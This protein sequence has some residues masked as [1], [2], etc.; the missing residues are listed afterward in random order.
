MTV[1]GLKVKDLMIPFSQCATVAQD[2]SLHEAVLALETTRLRSD[3]FDYRPR[4]LLVYDHDY[5]IV[6]TLRQHEVVRSLE[7]RYK[8]MAELV[9]EAGRPLTSDSALSI[10]RSRRMW[11][12]PLSEMCRKAS[13]IRVRDIMSVPGEGESISEEAPLQEA[14]HLLVL[15]NHL[16]LMV[17]GQKGFVGII[18]LSDVFFY[19]CTVIR[20]AGMERRDFATR[21]ASK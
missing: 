8:N 18:R 16:S 14:I 19:I 15:G 10:M 2:A 5:R 6:G 12:E 4:V 9:E 7:S 17:N 13:Q 20:S 1:N 21:G 3:R 11:R